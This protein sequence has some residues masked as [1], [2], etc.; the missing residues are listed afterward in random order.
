MGKQRLSHL[1]SIYVSWYG[2]LRHGTLHKKCWQIRVS[3]GI[4]Q[5]TMEQNGYIKSQNI[6]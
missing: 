6:G 5:N 2:E 1:S 3:L 4:I